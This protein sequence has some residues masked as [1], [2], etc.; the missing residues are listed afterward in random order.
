M[1][2]EIFKYYCVF[3]IVF[4]FGYI[5]WDVLRIISDTKPLKEDCFHSL[6][7]LQ[8]ED[9]AVCCKQLVRSGCG[10]ALAFCQGSKP[11]Y[12]CEQ[13]VYCLSG[14]LCPVF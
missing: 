6:F 14:P 5:F 10:T 2:E 11:M 9:K 7:Y 12:T 3:I 13:N 4:C 8:S 1:K